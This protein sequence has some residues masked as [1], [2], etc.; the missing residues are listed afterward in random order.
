M[1]STQEEKAKGGKSTGQ[2]REDLAGEGT[3]QHRE[4][5]TGGEST[6][7]HGGEHAG[8][9]N[10]GKHRKERTRQQRR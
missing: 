6:V 5:H 4:K 1:K 10:T 2:L 8:G 9:E 3:R 7:Q